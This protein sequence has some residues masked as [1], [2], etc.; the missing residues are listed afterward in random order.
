MVGDRLFFCALFHKKT[1]LSTVFKE[2]STGYLGNVKTYVPQVGGDS[3][4]K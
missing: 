2:F 3:E 4:N 1:F